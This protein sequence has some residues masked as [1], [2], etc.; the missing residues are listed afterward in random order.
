MAPEQIEKRGDV[1]HRAD[2]YSLGVVFYEML[3]GELPL[4]RFAAPSEKSRIDRRIDEIVMRTLEKERDRRFQTAEA[5]KTEVEGLG[6]PGGKRR[7]VVLDSAGKPLHG[8]R[9]G[10]ARLSG[11]ASAGATC[12]LLSTVLGVFIA[13][14]TLLERAGQNTGGIIGMAVPVALIAGVAGLVLGFDGLRQ[15]RRI[16]YLRGVRRG[17]FA[18]LGWPVLLMVSGILWKAYNRWPAFNSFAGGDGT[19][20]SSRHLDFFFIGPGGRLHPLLQSRMNPRGLESYT[21]P[22]LAVLACL[23]IWTAAALVLW[24]GLCRTALARVLWIILMFA[25]GG[26]VLWWVGTYNFAV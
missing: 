25:A 5:V 15:I 14:W 4:G 26:L 18:V 2:I 12:T 21:L 13:H 20:W 6:G 17:V 11:R 24:S 8:V 22:V 1:D 7:R 10:Q 3:T 23:L 19:G 9:F 16:G